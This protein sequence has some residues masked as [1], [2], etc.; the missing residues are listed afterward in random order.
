MERW[1]WD[2]HYE[3]FY[4]SDWLHTVHCQQCPRSYTSGRPW[5]WPIWH[6]HL[7]ATSMLRFLYARAIQVAKDLEHFGRMREA[8]VCLLQLVIYGYILKIHYSTVGWQI[9]SAQKAPTSASR[10][11][12]GSGELVQSSPVR[13]TKCILYKSR[14]NHGDIMV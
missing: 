14:P 8:D 13:Y 3:L 5:C 7:K 4:D 12:P 10:W 2:P 1:K 11:M 6:S 9:F